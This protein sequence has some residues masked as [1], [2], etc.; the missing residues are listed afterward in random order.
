MDEF[1]NKRELLKAEI[2]FVVEHF[3]ERSW[4][5]SLL[6]VQHRTRPTRK[7]TGR[8]VQSLIVAFVSALIVGIITGK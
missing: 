3:H 4:R 2:G 1:K 6:E 8:P 7:V 5:G